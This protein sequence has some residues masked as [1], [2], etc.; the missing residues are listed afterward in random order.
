[1][2][3]A[4]VSVLAHVT[5]AA[6]SQPSSEKPFTSF[7][8]V[9]A[10]MGVDALSIPSIAN[11]INAQVNPLPGQQIEAFSSGFEFTLSPEVRVSENWSAG[12]EYSYLLRTLTP[13]DVGG[14]H[15]WEFTVNAHM[16]T[17][18][19][20]Y[21]I[22]GTSY[23]LKVGGGAGYYFGRLLRS[24]DGTETSFH[25]DGIGFKLEAF[26]NTEFDEHFWGCIG[27]DLRWCYAGAL[28][29]QNG[30]SANMGQTTAKMNFFTA[31]VKFGVMVQ[32]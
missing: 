15:R 16:P 18:V 9:S 6:L 26:A 29:D 20:H 30:V 4:A 32:L 31:G 19:A 28:K 21:L 10:G 11:Y 25:A 5:E 3:I 2:R 24:V 27:V 14:F 13:T 23:W 17:A 8:H 22:S 12:L 7:I 1:M